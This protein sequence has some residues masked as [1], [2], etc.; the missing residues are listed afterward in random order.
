MT[1]I[2][3]TYGLTRSRISYIIK[4]EYEKLAQVDTIDKR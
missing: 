2:G 1:Q 4:A 3:E